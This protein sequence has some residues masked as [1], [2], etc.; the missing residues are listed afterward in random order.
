MSRGVEELRLPGSVGSS[1]G[2]KD[3]GRGL[4]S[5]GWVGSAA[6]RCLRRCVSVG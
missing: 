2:V 4:R 5:T 6:V 1:R 3:N